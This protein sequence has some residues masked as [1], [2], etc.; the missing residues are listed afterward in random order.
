MRTDRPRVAIVGA[1]GAVGREAIAILAEWGVPAEWIT[2][3]ASPRSVGATI[4]YGES[5]LIV[6]AIDVSLLADHDL[7]L[8]CASAGVGRDWAPTARALGALVVDASSAFRSDPLVPLVVPEINGHLLDDRPPLVASPNCSTILLLT[9]LEPIRRAF[10]VESIAVCTYQAISGAG[11][12]ALDEFRRQTA[13]ALAGDPITPEVFREPCAFNCFSHDSPVDPETGLNGEE[14]KI[15]A[16]ARRI[17]DD[18]GLPIDPTCI[19]VPVERAHSEAVSV[20]LREPATTAELRGALARA[21]G[22]RVVDDRAGGRFPTPLAATGIDGVLVGRLRRSPA[23]PAD[24][25]G[26]SRA[27]DLWLC[28]DQLRKG[29]ALNAL[30]IAGRL[31]PGLAQPAGSNSGVERYRSPN[32]QAMVTMR[33]AA[34]S[35]LEATR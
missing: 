19:R 11:R 7:A 16:E 17:W 14:R 5:T 2:P 1:T 25:Y 21:P 12:R 33:L 34:N 32:E 8:F 13:A 6:R 9:A 23:E 30:Q 27:H 3:L 10:G 28:G 15:I 29:A 31:L 26:R 4:P 35:G 18:P 20:R 22:V 24:E